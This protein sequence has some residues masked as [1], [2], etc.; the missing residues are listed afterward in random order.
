MFDSRIPVRQRRPYATAARPGCPTCRHRDQEDDPVGQKTVQ[1]SDL[2]GQLITGG[3]MPAR[4]VVQAHPGLAD[5]PVEIEALCGEATEIEKAGGQA[6]LLDLYFPGEEQPRRVVLDA[7]EFDRLATDRPMS[8]ILAMARRAKPARR[9]ARSAATREQATGRGAEP[10]TRA[11]REAAVR[12]T[13]EP[14]TGAPPEPPTEA[15]PEQVTG[16]A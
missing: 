1:F 13:R 2:S 11:A 9:S 10:V 8:E 16:A 3:E 5:G 14:A 4:V 6:V 12:A 7:A 15:T